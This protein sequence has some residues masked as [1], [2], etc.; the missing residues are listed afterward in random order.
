[1]TSHTDAIW[2]V[3][4]EVKDPEIPVLSVVDLGIVREVKQLSPKAFEITI[5]PTYSSCP[6]MDTIEKEIE[7]LLREKGYECAIKTTLSPA[8]TTDWLSEKGRKALEDYGIAPPAES[9]S[10]KSFLTGEAKEVKCP[11]CKSTSTQLISQFGS[12]ACKALY[13]CDDC[14]ESFDYFK[15]I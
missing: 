11:L 2:Q 4:E 6:A 9:T 14:L 12:T 8:W 3:L 15:C 10:D 5:T 13:R 7:A 1:M